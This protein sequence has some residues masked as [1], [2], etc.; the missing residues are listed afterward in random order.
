M[1]NYEER[2]FFLAHT[3]LNY[4]L[5]CM[6]NFLLSRIDDNLK[7]GKRSTIPNA[8]FKINSLIVMLKN[9]KS[10]LLLTESDN[11]GSA[12]S[13]L[14]ALIESIFV[15]LSIYDNEA[16]ANEYYK[17][18]D[19]RITYEETGQYPQSFLDILPKNVQRQNYLNYG[20]LDFF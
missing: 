18:M 8:N 14:R 20:W 13:L 3:P 19:F 17:F 11:C 5:H 2:N 15:Y 16:V 1:Q 4:S 6:V 9:I 10:I 7:R 12:F